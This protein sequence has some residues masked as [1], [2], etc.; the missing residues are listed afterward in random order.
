MYE[1]PEGVKTKFK[2]HLGMRKSL[3]MIPN[4]ECMDIESIRSLIIDKYL[5]ESLG[6]QKLHNYFIFYILLGFRESRET[7]NWECVRCGV[8]E[9]YGP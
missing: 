7:C 8:T 2:R 3:L 4:P 9:K 1:L 6:S 5:G